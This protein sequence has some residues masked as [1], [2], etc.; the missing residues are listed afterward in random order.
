MKELDMGFVKDVAQTGALGLLPKLVAGKKKPAPTGPQPMITL[1][2]QPRPTSMI[3][4][5]RSI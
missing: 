5:T 3:G 4:S 2:N 1:T